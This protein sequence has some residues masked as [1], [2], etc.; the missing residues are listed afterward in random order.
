LLQHGLAIGAFKLSLD[1][2]EMNQRV[3]QLALVMAGLG[4]LSPPARAQDSAPPPPEER[5]SQREEMEKLLKDQTLY[6]RYTPSGK[7]W[8]EYQS[9][10]GRTAYREEDC[11]YAGHWWIQGELVC[12]RYDAFN[13]GR[14][15]C[16]GLFHRNG[17][18]AFYLPGPFG[19]WFLNAYT[20]DHRV[21]NPDKM[22]VQGQTCVGV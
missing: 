3:L 14:P 18:L 17:E 12:Y 4:F 19:Q 20:T 9:P 16:F 13:E 22:P 11:T 15:A 1:E 7:P 5:V 6:G 10:D 2:K 8:A 21:G